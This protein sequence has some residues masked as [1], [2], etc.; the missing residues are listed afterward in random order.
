[1][2]EEATLSLN[3]LIIGTKGVMSRVTHT[4]GD[5]YVANFII[6]RISVLITVVFERICY[7]LKDGMATT[8]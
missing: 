7:V 1:M 5:L 4:I 2:A 3:V 8:M 6:L